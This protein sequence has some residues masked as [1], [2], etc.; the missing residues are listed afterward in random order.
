MLRYAV[1][2]KC[3]ACGICVT[4]TDLVVENAVGI[5][6]P[7]KH[8]YISAEALSKAEQ[9]VAKCPM[10]ALS[11]V[12]QNADGSTSSYQSGSSAACSGNSRGSGSCNQVALEALPALLAKRFAAIP[13]PEIS[14]QDIAFDANNYSL[15]YP[16]PQGEYR[17][18]YSSEE[19]ANKAGLA[20]F[21]RIA[22]S[23]FR[24]FNL[25]V[26]VQYKLDKLKTFYSLDAEGF[27]PK[28]NQRYEDLLVEF[29][30]QAQSLSGG[31]VHFP[32][33]FTTFAAF[34][35][36]DAGTCKK[37]YLYAL[38]HY[39]EQSTCSG[40]MQ[41]FRSGACSSLADYQ[42]YFD[43]DDQETYEGEGFFGGSK[44][45]YKYC[46]CNVRGAVDEYLKDLKYSMNYV[47]V[48]KFAWSRIQVIVQAYQQEAQKLCVQKLQLFKE[49]LN[50]HA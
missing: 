27:I 33:D 24:K 15:D 35:G 45:K 16:Y 14:K 29:V 18:D 20:E 28:L 11:I 17:Y 8:A 22:Y 48:D 31:Q 39:D 7:A 25:S 3:N 34:P 50:W 42:C 32:A 49:A 2:D 4:L 37:L 43:T 21:N 13:L 41:E 10:Q 12:Q 46:Y 6:E 19:K 47:D 1:S 23:Q 26:F 44:Y 40:I 36:G 9:I 30:N 38:E 5:A